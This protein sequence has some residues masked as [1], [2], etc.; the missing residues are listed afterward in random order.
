VAF[1]DAFKHA[2][3][4]ESTDPIEPTDEQRPIVERL[5]QEVVRRRLTVPALMFLEM[6]RPLGYLAAQTIHFFTPLISAV[7]DAQSHKHLAAFLE[8][9]QSVEYLC[10]RIEQLEAEFSRPSE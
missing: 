6:S 4:V 9:R 3:A 7:T 10:R 1:L 8:H 2:F 5:C